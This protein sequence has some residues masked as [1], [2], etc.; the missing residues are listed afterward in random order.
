MNRKV[1]LIIFCAS[2]LVVSM[3]FFIGS[4]NKDNKQEEAIRSDKEAIINRF[5]NVGDFEKCYWKGGVMGSGSRWVPGPSDY[6]MKGFIE[7]DADKVKYFIEKYD[8]KVL[9]ENLEL[10][11]VPE[12][13]NNTISKW[14]YSEEF[15]GF[16]KEP[17]FL[18]NFY[19]DSENNMIYFEVVIS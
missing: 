14:F 4:L 5:P 1:V 13:Y 16:I 17:R 19:I 10:A 3:V 2:V 9:D 15:N 8:M 12:D 7:I 11:F 18:G 6:W